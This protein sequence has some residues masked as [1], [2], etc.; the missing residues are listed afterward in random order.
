MYVC[1][2][3]DIVFVGGGGGGGIVRFS[4]FSLIYLMDRSILSLSSNNML[5]GADLLDV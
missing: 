3:L 5:P 1:A 2:R 4:F